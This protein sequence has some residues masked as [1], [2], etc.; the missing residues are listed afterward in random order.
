VISYS[1]AQRTGEFGIRIA[2]GASATNVQGIVL[3]EGLLLGL[4]GVALG[5]AAATLLTRF[6]QSLLFGV[7]A[8]DPWTF[9]LMAA[10]LVAVVLV[11][12]FFP[13]RRATRVDPL[14]ALRAE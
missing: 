3:K 2:I 13:A 10:A 14:V 11:A 1:V 5:M 12:S 8:S 7:Q 9:G 6:I 4:F